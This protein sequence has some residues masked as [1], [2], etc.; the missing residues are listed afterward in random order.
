MRVARA[1]SLLEVIFVIVIIGILSSYAIPKFT[2]LRDNA[3]VS[4]ELSTASSVSSA[5]ASCHGEW[6]IND[7]N[8]TCGFNI[9]RDDFNTTTGYP[10]T[11]KL[12]TSDSSPLDRILKNGKKIDWRRDDDYSPPRFYGP[13][14]GK[15]NLGDDNS[16]NK[17][18]GDDYWVYS[19]EN[20][21]FSLVKQ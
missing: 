3:K 6:I 12:G 20:G 11:D 13:T 7:A 1:F 14:Y 17:P 16:S 5:V 2:H 18:D 9:S 15:V 4:A 8:F 21:T 10:L 19:E